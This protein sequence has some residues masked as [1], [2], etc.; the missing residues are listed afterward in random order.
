MTINSTWLEKDFKQKYFLY[1][2]YCKAEPLIIKPNKEI[3]IRE[4]RIQIHETT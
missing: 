1:C 3:A 2:K 4:S